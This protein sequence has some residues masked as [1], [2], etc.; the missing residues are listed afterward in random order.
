M[1]VRVAVTE[2][3]QREKRELSAQASMAMSVW[4]GTHLTKEGISEY[5]DDIMR[6]V[7]SSPESDADNSTN[8]VVV[9]E[10]W[11][12]FMSMF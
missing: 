6:R 5:T 7:E 11:K 12:K 8:P 1:F 2:K 9:E 4:A 3:R 10:N